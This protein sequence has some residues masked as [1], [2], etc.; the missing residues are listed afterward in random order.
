VDDKGS[1]V[2][3]GTGLL[4]GAGNNIGTR[5]GVANVVATLACGPVAAPTLFHSPPAPLDLA[6]NF[7]IRGALTEDGVNPAVMP[8][9]CENPVLLIRSFNAATG[10]GNWFAAGIPRVR[11]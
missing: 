7:R 5:G 4:F 9:T 3:R 10:P 11:N 6:G 8:P 1:I 2:A